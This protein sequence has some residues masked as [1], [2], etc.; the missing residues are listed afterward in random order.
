MNVKEKNLQPEGL[1]IHIPFC[2]SKCG[3]CGFYSEPLSGHDPSAFISAVIAEID[4]YETIGGIHTVYIGGGSPSCL[5]IDLLEQLLTKINTRCHDTE[6]FTV[7]INPGQT[8]ADLFKMLKNHNV[9]RLSIG[10]QSF[11]DTQL[12][13]LGRGHT[14]QDIYSCVG[15]ARA[16]GFENINLDLIFAL[17][18]ST[19]Q[20]WIQNLN[21]AIDLGPEHISAYSLSFEQDTDFAEALKTGSLKAVGEDLDR[22]MYESAIDLLEQNGF[23]Q[24]EI[25]NF[26]R[27]GFKCRHN[28]L[29]WANKQY[30]GIGPA[31]GS[32]LGR[33]HILNIDNIKTYIE[34]I[35]TGISPAAEIQQLTDMEFACETAVL[36]LRRRCGIILEVFKDQTGLNAQKLFTEAIRKNINAKLLEQT[37]GAIRLTR[38]ALGVADRV[39]CD[40]STP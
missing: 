27:K 23:E 32:F 13:L 19:H 31:A 24:Y 3:Y 35:N 16:A 4:L 8:D 12:K 26:G 6:E 10:A 21:S 7:E 30:I 29:Y 38:G 28:L 5:S 37:N 22:Q 2:S 15:H 40:F 25:S 11:N 39:L 20:Q 9:N 14:V 33:E 17:P 36:N 34:N 1:Y 18:Y